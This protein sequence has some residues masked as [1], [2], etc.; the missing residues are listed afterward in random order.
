M[1]VADR[2][3][4][5]ARRP[6]DRRGAAD[7]ASAPAR[8]RRC[9][10]RSTRCSTQ[11]AQGDRARPAR[12]R[13]RPAR[14]GRARVEHLHRGRQ[15]RV[16]PRA[17]SG[18]SAIE[19]AAGRRD[20]PED[21]GRRA[22]RRRQRQRLRDRDR[23]AAR[24]PPRDRGRHE[25]VRQGRWCRRSSR[26]R[27][28]A[29]STSPSANYYLPGGKTISTKGIK[30]QVRAVDKPRTKRDEALPV[31]LDVLAAQAVSA[32]VRGRPARRLDQPLVAV[33]EKRGRFLVAEPL[34]GHGPRTR[35]SS[36]AGAGEGDLVL[37]G[38]GKR[39]ARVLRRLGTA[40][41]G[42]R[43]A[44]GPDARPRPAPQLRRAARPRRR[45]PADE[46]YAADARVDLTR[47]AHLH[48]R[49]RRRQGLRRR[50]LGA[51]RGRPRAR[52]GSTSPT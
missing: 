28:A 31:A 27:T 13:R 21:P 19:N 9:A 51:P 6:E 8:T 16:R 2:P 29:T 26:S 11:G 14:R 34:F 42:A 17:A 32:A 23:R 41:R 30:P 5:R 47:A 20:R 18:A 44:R 46:P 1:P 43:R 24:P 25:H 40:R 35:R 3:R 48:D 7:R 36:A 33:L 38:S 37:V 12:Q 50:D 10:A 15:D 49:P 52:S 39:G 22:G 45:P 4:G